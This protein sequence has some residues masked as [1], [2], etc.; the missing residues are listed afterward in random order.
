[1]N[2]TPRV[3]LFADTFHETNGAANF[4]RRLVNFAQKK[5]YPLL[6]IRSGEKTRHF[7]DGSVSFLDLKRGRA[8]IPMDGALRYD[9]FL[10]KHKKLVGKTLEEFAPNVIHI[11]GLN[12]I[13]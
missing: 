8:S 7:R 10:W 4:L 6:C 11:T 2:Q 3:A 12:D 1:M 9:P 5:E 13:S